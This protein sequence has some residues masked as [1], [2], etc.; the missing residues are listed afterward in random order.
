MKF[1]RAR[2]STKRFLLHSCS[3]SISARILKALIRQHV[4]VVTTEIQKIKSKDA[5]KALEFTTQPLA[6]MGGKRVS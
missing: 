2:L 3:L 6:A 1:Q 5:R 4:I